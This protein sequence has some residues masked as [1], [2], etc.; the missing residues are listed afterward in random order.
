MLD[1]TKMNEMKKLEK[2]VSFALC[3]YD[4]DMRV[5]AE[6]VVFLLSRADSPGSGG[7]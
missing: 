1:E 7:C 3:T 2:R 6:F 5:R 4:L